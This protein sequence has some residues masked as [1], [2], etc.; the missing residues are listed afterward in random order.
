MNRYE[1]SDFKPKSL[2]SSTAQKV[3][4]LQ[5]IEIAKFDKATGLLDRLL[6]QSL[7]IVVVQDNKYEKIFSIIFHCSLTFLV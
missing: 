2:A 3:R 6:L 1:I 7:P 4:E 5:D